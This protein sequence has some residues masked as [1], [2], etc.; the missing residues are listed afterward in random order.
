M[1]RSPQFGFCIRRR[2][3]SK[4]IG[5][6]LAHIRLRMPQRFAQPRHGKASGGQDL[7]A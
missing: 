5:S 7:V 4:N 3:L 1:D 2:N 6:G